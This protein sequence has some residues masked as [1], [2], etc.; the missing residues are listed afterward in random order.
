MKTLSVFLLL[1]LSASAQP[2]RADDR[3]DPFASRIPPNVSPDAVLA[4]GDP[5]LTES[6]VD[7][8]NNLEAWLYELPRTQ[9]QRN[10]A[11]AMMIED[12]KK[13]AEIKKYMSNLSMAAQL[14][15]ATPSQREFIRCQLQPGNLQSSRADKDNPDAQRIVA[16]YEQSHQPIAFGDPPLTES[17]VSR[18]TSYLGWVLQIRLTQPLKDN[19][20]AALLQDWK[21]PKEIKSDMD[22]LNW[23]VDMANRPNEEKEYFRS[24]AEPEIIKAMRVDRG[25][26]AAPWIVA[27]YDAAHPS[28]AAG[29]P[30]LTRQAADAL[31]ELLCFIRSH[32]SGSRQEADQAFKDANAAQ[33]AQNYPKLSS[34]QQQK[35]AQM[36]QDWAMLRLA[37]V[38]GSEADRQKMVAQWRPMVQPSQPVD[39]PTDTVSD[40]AAKCEE[41]FLKKDAATT[42]DFELMLGGRYCATF[43]QELRRKGGQQNLANAVRWERAASDLRAAADRM[44]ERRAAQAKPE[45]PPS[46][47]TD[48]R[49]EAAMAALRRIG[50]FLE[51]DATTVSEQEMLTVAK[52]CDFVAQEWRR[53]G[54][55]EGAPVWEQSARNLRAGKVAYLAYLKQ[56]AAAN[57]QQTAADWGSVEGQEAAARVRAFEKKDPITVSEQEVQRAARD[58][59]TVAREQ[60][61]AGSEVNLANAVT[62]EQYSRNLRNGKEAWVKL[63]A[64]NAVNRYNALLKRDPNTVSEQDLAAAANDAHNVAVYFRRQGPEYNLAAAANWERE[65][66][67]VSV[68]RDAWVRQRAAQV[69]NGSMTA[70]QFQYL[71]NREEKHYGAVMNGIGNMTGGYHYEIRH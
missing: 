46:Q 56:Q 6:M 35:L 29:N 61:R 9:Q 63:C 20:R 39:P 71:W 1:A 22:F 43:A 40:A 69:P 70:E 62:W 23:Q 54:N 66:G 25:N 48:P 53:E 27:A 64:Q 30:P 26:P 15:Q 16:A 55:L 44:G 7:V 24:K 17:M 13:P 10:S 21:Q 19:L 47:Q 57:Q 5:P 36:P 33:L 59:D 42:G 67:S 60:R 34:E 50:A 28:I 37:W 32:G 65:A 4:K 14:A 49:R 68:G 11:R 52:D 31:A 38:K 2:G 12:W 8:Y 51:K 18:F 3:D 41:V 58:C 45:P